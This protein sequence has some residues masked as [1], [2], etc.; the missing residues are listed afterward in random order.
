MGTCTAVLTTERAIITVLA[1]L[2]VCGDRYR[3]RVDPPVEQV[4]MMS[5]LMHPQRTGRIA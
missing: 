1:Q 4:K 3:L 2:S 5:G